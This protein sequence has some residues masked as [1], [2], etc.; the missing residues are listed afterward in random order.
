MK[1][2]SS[3]SSY[4]VHAH[5]ASKLHHDRLVVAE[6][7]EAEA[8]RRVVRRLFEHAREQRLVPLVRRRAP[9]H[10][11]RLRLQPLLQVEHVLAR[12]VERVEA[13][14]RE[15]RRRLA[16]VAERVDL[17]GD[18]RAATPAERQIQ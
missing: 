16:T 13:H 5:V 10:F 3:G 7:V 11:G 18:A 2:S 8:R 6:L 4:T 14:A 12:E 17:P 9:D 1:P 15:Q